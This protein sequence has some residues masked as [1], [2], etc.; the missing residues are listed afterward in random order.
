MKVPFLFIGGNNNELLLP[1]FMLNNKAK[2]KY[3]QWQLKV[4]IIIYGKP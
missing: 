3:M 2:Q 1:H 4:I